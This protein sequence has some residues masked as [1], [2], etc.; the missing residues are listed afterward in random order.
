MTT[1]RAT[2]SV[3]PDTRSGG[4]AVDLRGLG[5]TF[6]PVTALEGVDLQIREGELVSLLGASG[7]GKTTLLRLIS[8]FD[9]PTSGEIHLSGRE[10]SSLSPA[11][12][13]IGMVFQ[14]YALFPHKTVRQNVEYGLVMRK[15]SKPDRVRR[16]DEMLDRMR[17]TGYGDRLPREL[18]GGQQQRVAIARAL[19]F[20]PK[21][22]LMDE[23]LGALDRALKENLLEE[24]RR[25]HREFGTT[26]IYVTHDREEALTL[27]DRIALMDA[28]R[29][30]VCAPVEELYLTPPTAFAASFISGAAILPLG[31]DGPLRVVGRGDGAMTVSDGVHTAEFRAAAAATDSLALAVRPVG[32][33]AATAVG[34]G[35]VVRG[36]VAE[37]VFLGDQIR[38]RA[39]LD[40]FG[41]TVSALLSL[42]DGHRLAAGDAV[43]F[44][45]HPAAATIVAA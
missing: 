24:I 39:T 27:S 8:G 28:A 5:K 20:R 26:I 25:V 41:T 37:T 17:L 3:T 15:W 12:R 42:V 23:P 31:G 16:V 35:P 6:G 43:S 29:L 14:N 4:I 9:S 11:S 10:V 18:S 33:D 22:L 44:R 21:V 7:S 36:T 30:K 38:V 40:G 13:D 34:D 32:F 45:I 1:I 19:A 2:P